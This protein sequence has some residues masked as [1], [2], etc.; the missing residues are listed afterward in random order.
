M[1]ECTN[2]QL[3]ALI[4]TVQGTEELLKYVLGSAHRTSFAWRKLFLYVNEDG[5]NSRLRSWAGHPRD[6]ENMWTHEY[7]HEK[8]LGHAI[9]ISDANA[10]LPSCYPYTHCDVYG[11]KI[12]NEWAWVNVNDADPTS[13]S[14]IDS[15]VIENADNYAWFATA[16]WFDSHF[17]DVN[18]D[19]KSSLRWDLKHAGIA[20][21]G[22]PKRQVAD[23]THTA[24][25]ATQT[26]G[27]D[28]LDE[29]GD[30]VN[31]GLVYHD[32]AEVQEEPG[33]IADLPDPIICAPSVED[34]G[35]PSCQYIGEEY[36]SLV[37]GD[38]EEP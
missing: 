23:E 14:S 9:T 22:K 10:K 38:S 37:S 1:K 12:T 35:F 7:M 13:Y 3:D 29:S 6:L 5:L 27:L 36:A 30:Q 28:I 33:N 34:D 16:Y 20:Q 15:Q 2:D 32:D 19:R 18:Y 11:A 25:A 8:L 31:G 26:A 4:D 17:L 21:D 24:D